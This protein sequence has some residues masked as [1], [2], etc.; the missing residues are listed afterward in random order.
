MASRNIRERRFIQPPLVPTKADEAEDK[1]IAGS[2]DPA[3]KRRQASVYDAV[4]GLCAL[5]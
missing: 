2:E 4:A 5:Q 3:L 1:F